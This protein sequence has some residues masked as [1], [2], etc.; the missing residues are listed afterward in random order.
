MDDR[1]ALARFGSRVRKLREAHGL[2][3]EELAE[4]A[5]LHRTYIGSVERGERNISLINIHRI[6]RALRVPPG[7]LL[8]DE[9]EG[10]SVEA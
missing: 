8:A 4:A 7:E 1:D 3:Q 10:E 5:H 9:G 2:S 6:A